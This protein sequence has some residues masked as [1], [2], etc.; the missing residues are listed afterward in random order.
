[1]KTFT[2]LEIR[3]SNLLCQLDGDLWR[4]MMGEINPPKHIAEEQ[5]ALDM[6]YR[7]SKALGGYIPDLMSIMRKHVPAELAEAEIQALKG[8]LGYIQ[9]M[10]RSLLLIMLVP[11][12][13]DH[14]DL[15]TTFNGYRQ[16]IIFVEDYLAQAGK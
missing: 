10:I 1:M 12:Y 4:K 5:E 6:V 16:T 9:L 14:E 2:E 11:R 15:I 13:H 3:L 8:I 7:G